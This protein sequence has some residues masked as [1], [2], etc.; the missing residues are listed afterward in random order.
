MDFKFDSLL[1]VAKG[2]VPIRQVL[3]S[4]AW[5]G[6]Q[7]LGGQLYQ[8][9]RP[10]QRSRR[11]IVQD[12]R[13]WYDAVDGRLQGSFELFCVLSGVTPENQSAQREYCILAG[14]K[15]P[16]LEGQKSSGFIP[17]YPKTKKTP[18]HLLALITDYEA[19]HQSDLFLLCDAAGINEK[20]ARLF[21]NE[22]ISTGQLARVELPRR[23]PF[24]PVVGYIRLCND[25]EIEVG[26]DLAL[27]N[28]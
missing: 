2:L 16:A 19:V 26:P 20:Y 27:D 13:S 18:A 8:L 1:R 3:D 9:N 4:R 23:T 15:V 28:R 21:L 14:L 12:P 6:L 11:L 25:S 10:M 17:P 24:E 5:V 7:H 22:L